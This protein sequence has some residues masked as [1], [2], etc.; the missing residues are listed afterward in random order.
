MLNAA[1]SLLSYNPGAAAE[2][3]PE[4][5]DGD[6]TVEEL[7]AELELAVDR[8]AL[9]GGV[10][11]NAEGLANNALARQLRDGTDE[12][13]PWEEFLDPQFLPEGVSTDI[14]KSEG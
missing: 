7:T 14:P 8:G 12:V 4:A 1:V 9:D 11:F 5:A 13:V 2:I 10:G 6:F 3:Y